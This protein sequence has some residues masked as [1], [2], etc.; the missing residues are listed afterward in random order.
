M[1]VEQQVKRVRWASWIAPVF[2]LAL[3]AVFLAAPWA[4]KVKLDAV[5]FGI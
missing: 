3:V 2:L 1:T 4:L 5:C